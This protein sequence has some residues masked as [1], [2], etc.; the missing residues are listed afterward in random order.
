M[1]ANKI[2]FIYFLGGFCLQ[3]LKKSC[4]NN[5]FKTLIEAS[6]VLQRDVLVSGC[7]PDNILLNQC[8]KK[9]KQN[10][11]HPKLFVKITFIVFFLLIQV[12][13]L[14]L[15]IRESLV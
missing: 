1:Q 11:K 6:V 2:V 15:Y 5:Y 4:K 12:F 14:L 10:K 3:C 7:S 9:K 8:S 13:F